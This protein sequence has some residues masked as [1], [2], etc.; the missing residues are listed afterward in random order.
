M[1]NKFEQIVTD[2]GIASYPWLNYPDDQFATPG[3]YKLSLILTK[4][5]AAPLMK[6]IDETHARAKELGK[7]KKV[8]PNNLPYKEQLDDQEQPTGNYILNFK[9]KSKINMKDGSQIDIKPMIVDSKG[10]KMGNEQ[11]WGGTKCRVSA[12]L[13]PYLRGSNYGCT[14]R[15]KAVQIIDLVSSKNGDMSSHGFKEEKGYESPDTDSATKDEVPEEA[16]DF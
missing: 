13:V 5:Q 7:G 12:L 1:A 15:L 10:R 11:I 9:Q 8:S 16:E 14:M 2:I 3:D 4:E 6:K